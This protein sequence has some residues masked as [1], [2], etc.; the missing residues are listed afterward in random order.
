MIAGAAEQ[1]PYAIIASAIR[2]TAFVIV[3]YMEFTRTGIRLAADFASRVSKQAFD[4]LDTEIELG[5]QAVM[6]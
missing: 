4:H 6:G 5:L 3:I 2:P 1:A